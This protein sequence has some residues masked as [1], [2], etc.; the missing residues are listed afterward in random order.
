MESSG[1]KCQIPVDPVVNEF[2]SQG[3]NPTL[4]MILKCP[5][6]LQGPHPNWIVAPLVIISD[7][8]EYDIVVCLAGGA[9][10]IQTIFTRLRTHL[11]V[12]QCLLAK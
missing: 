4:V 5:S 7:V 6:T 12:G 3:N 9:Q 8:K 1:L 11:L 10:N 2:L